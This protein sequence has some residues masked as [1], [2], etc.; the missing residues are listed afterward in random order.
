MYEVKF[1]RKDMTE[2]QEAIDV[3]L[4]TID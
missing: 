2:Y 3:L 1:E 4:K